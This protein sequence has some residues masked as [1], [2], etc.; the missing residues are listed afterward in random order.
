MAVTKGDLWRGTEPQDL[1]EFL[2]DFTADQYPAKTI[3]HARCEACSGVEFDVRLDDDE[4]CAERTCGA[5]G[6][7]FA[8][9]DSADHLEEA[10]LGDA[11]CPCGGE[12]FN[13]AVGFAQ[14]ADTD[15]VRW[16]YLALRCIADGTLGCYADWK[17]DYAPSMHL[18]G[19]V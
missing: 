17:I 4:G 12:R 11:A 19:A 10:D 16:V 9:L 7:T 18:L 15:E 5:C 1:D 8:L 14:M 2:A 6:S 3:V 13:I